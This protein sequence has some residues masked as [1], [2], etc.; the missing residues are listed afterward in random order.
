MTSNRPKP[1]F[2]KYLQAEHA[3]TAI[4]SKRIK[5]ATIDDLNDLFD[6]RP[7]F[8]S[9]SGRNKTL[10][11]ELMRDWRKMFAAKY[12]MICMSC[13][14]EDPALWA[15][16]STFHTGIVIEFSD[17]PNEE[18]FE[19][20][21]ENNPVRINI[22]DYVVESFDNIFKQ[23]ITTKF[24]SWTYE[25]EVR[26]F[27]DL[28]QCILVGGLYFWEFPSNVIRSLILG[29]K[30]RLDDQYMHRLLPQN[31]LLNV[32]VYR[33]TESRDKFTIEIKEILREG[34]ERLVM[35]EKGPST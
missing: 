23:A 12:G 10:A 3:L 32:R 28:D 31:N 20:K 34:K 16:Y 17:I 4:E 27:V 22:D 26:C 35:L 11:D 7:V 30:C 21:Y 18:F 25:S 1:P 19:V 13:N 24:K 6:L 14:K 29:V 8:I 33:G 5:V 9:E 2:F 15:H